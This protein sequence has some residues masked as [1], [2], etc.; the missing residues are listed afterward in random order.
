MRYE[1]ITEYRAKR[2][3]AVDEKPHS[4][5]YTTTD[6]CRGSGSKAHLKYISGEQQSRVCWIFVACGS[7]V[8]HPH[9]WI[10]WLPKGD[11][12]AKQVVCQRT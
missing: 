4:H 12:I 6:D 11:T 5:R 9:K 8:P 3:G 7:K 2:V 1:R 10:T